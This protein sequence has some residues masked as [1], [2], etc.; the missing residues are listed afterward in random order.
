MSNIYTNV[1]DMKLQVHTLSLIITI[2][3]ATKDDIYCNFIIGLCIWRSWGLFLRWQVTLIRLLFRCN[4]RDKIY[5]MWYNIIII[6]HIFCV[7]FVF[8]SNFLD[9]ASTIIFLVDLY[10]FL[11]LLFLFFPW[12]PFLTLLFLWY[13]WSLS[14]W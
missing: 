6:S 8:F 4:F 9:T 1:L 10:R 3:V 7:S 11:L 14:L 13:S 12:L 5:I 2:L